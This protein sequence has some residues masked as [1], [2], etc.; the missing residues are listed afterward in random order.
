MAVCG[1]CFR[2]CNIPEGGTGFCGARTCQDGQVVPENYGKITALMLDPIEKK[3]LSRFHPGSRILSVGSYGCNLRCPFCQNYDISWGEAVNIREKKS[4][5]ITPQELAD[6]ALFYRDRG[7][8]GV[9]FT[10]N[11]PLIGYEFVRDTAKIVHEAG[12]L[13]V[14]VSNGTAELSVLEELLPYIDGMNIDLKGFTDEY[15][16]EVL[17]GSRKMVMDFIERAVKD[18]HVELTTLII[19]GENDSEDEIR[20]MSKWIAGLKDK[21]ENVMGGDIPLHISRFFPRFHMTDRDAT[22]VKKVY[23]LAEIAREELRYVYTGN[24]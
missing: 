14:L 2:H 13:N 1:V 7:N 4:E 19:P 16:S 11:E 8:I 21:D 6:T 12:M 5:E 22:E 10:Y 17:D 23:R 18:C 20:R 15:Y 3:P 9:A 24:C